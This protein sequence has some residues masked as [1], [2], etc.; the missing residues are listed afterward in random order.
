MKS[1]SQD[2]RYLQRVVE[3]KKKKTKILAN[4]SGTLVVDKLQMEAAIPND[5][6]EEKK[7]EKVGKARTRTEE[8]RHVTS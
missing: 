5:S 6:I 7:Y 3:N 1:Q 2:G 8:P 4:Q